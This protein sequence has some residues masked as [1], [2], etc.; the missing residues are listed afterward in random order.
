MGTPLL[1]GNGC[2]HRTAIND[3][4]L[5]KGGKQKY[6]LRMHAR[7]V[8]IQM[9]SRRLAGLTTGGSVSISSTVHSTVSRALGTIDQSLVTLRRSTSSLVSK[10]LCVLPHC[11]GRR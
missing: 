6:P 10:F 4:I 2:E 1:V 7:V 11:V 3:H 5:P 9:D 8:R